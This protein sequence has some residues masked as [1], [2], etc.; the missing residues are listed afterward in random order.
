MSSVYPVAR[1]TGAVL[2]VAIGVAVLGERLSPSGRVGVVL[3]L[4]GIAVAALPGARRATLVP[5]LLT[6]VAIAGYSALDRV[7]VR[8]GSAYLYAAVICA[9]AAVGLVAFTAITGAARR[10]AALAAV[11]S[12]PADVATA[13]GKASSVRR[14]LAAGV[15]MIATYMLVLVALQIAPLSGVAPL[16]ES[17]TVLAAAW[18]VIVLGER[19]HAGWRARRSSCRRPRRHPARRRVADPEPAPAW[20]AAGPLPVASGSRTPRQRSGRRGLRP[21]DPVDGRA[22]EPSEQRQDEDRP[23][24]AQLLAPVER[25]ELL[26]GRDRR[27]PRS[28]TPAPRPGSAGRRSPRRW[29]SRRSGRRRRRFGTR[30]LR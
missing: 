19:D 21:H 17:A 8:M 11:G 23:R 13:D 22:A 18:G 20:S 2:A 24:R 25:R 9:V 29:C 3:L 12:T 10:A 15:L 7:G 26:D 28:L 1:G 14:S 27:L 30:C 16:R 4:G 5:A 6:G